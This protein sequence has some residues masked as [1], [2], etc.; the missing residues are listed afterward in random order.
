MTSEE[1]AQTTYDE[2]ARMYQRRG[3]DYYGESSDATTMEARWT[4]ANRNRDGTGFLS[5]LFLVVRVRR[6]S[7]MNTILRTCF[8]ITLTVGV[9][10]SVSAQEQQMGIGGIA[11]RCFIQV[12]T[13]RF[14]DEYVPILLC[15]DGS[16]DAAFRIDFYKSGRA[17]L[18]LYDFD[19]ADT[20]RTETATATFQIGKNTPFQIND[21]RAVITE[22]A[23][24]F[25]LSSDQ[26][27]SILSQVASE[28]T[29]RFRYQ[30][31]DAALL[32]EVPIPDYTSTLVDQFDLIRSQLGDN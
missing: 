12:M 22:Y 14:T 13:D 28:D 1:I 20:K 25:E 15:I 6:I 16:L 10:V 3:F 9:V 32:R 26:L 29:S 23:K 8:L 19:L 21:G 18:H 4:F 17:F 7:G 11:E 30:L 24:T 27:E 2:I 31:G 5:D